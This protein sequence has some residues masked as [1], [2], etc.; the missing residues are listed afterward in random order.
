MLFRNDK[1]IRGF[2]ELQS[3]FTLSGA[4]KGLLDRGNTQLYGL[5][6]DNL[7]RGVMSKDERSL[8]KE[9]ESNLGRSLDHE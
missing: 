7:D 4:L 8:R 5:I 9:R 3:E 1:A 2:V 6:F